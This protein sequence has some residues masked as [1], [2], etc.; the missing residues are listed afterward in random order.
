M[1]SLIEAFHSI[2]LQKKLC[3]GCTSSLNQCIKRENVDSEVEL[4]TCRCGRH[5]IYEK[6]TEVYKKVSDDEYEKYQTY[7]L[8]KKILK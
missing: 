3:A 5:Y 7:L 8:R 1:T 6:T 4:V 2:L